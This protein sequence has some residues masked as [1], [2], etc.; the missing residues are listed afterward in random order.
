MA[1]PS[2]FFKENAMQD[3]V[4]KY[5]NSL[6]L[7][8]ENGTAFKN[9]PDSVKKILESKDSEK[10]RSFFSNGQYLADSVRSPEA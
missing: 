2:H 10:V 1:A 5:F 3:Q 6:V 8:S 9:M 7:S 4:I